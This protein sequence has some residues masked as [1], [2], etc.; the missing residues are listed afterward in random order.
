MTRAP[1]DMRELKTK[2]PQTPV[3]FLR[4]SARDWLNR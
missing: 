4:V 2:S 3:K 1:L